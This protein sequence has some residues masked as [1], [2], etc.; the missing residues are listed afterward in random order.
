[1]HRIPSLRRRCHLVEKFGSHQIGSIER[2]EIRRFISDLSKTEPSANSVR[3]VLNVIKGICS[4][5]V[6]TGPLH[7]LSG[8]DLR[9]RIHR[10]SGWRTRSAALRV[11]DLD[12]M[13]GRIHVHRAVAEVHGRMETGS[14]KSGGTPS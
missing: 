12:L 1:M 11:G 2:Y 6:E 14:P 9:R 8:S 13:R 10:P 3:N 7:S 5:A 4:R